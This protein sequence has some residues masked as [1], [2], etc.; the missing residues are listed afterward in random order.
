MGW[1]GGT[2]TKGNNS[3]GGWTGDA[4]L[5]IGRSWSSRHPGR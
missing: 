1:S 2:Y 4:S 3:T 5:G